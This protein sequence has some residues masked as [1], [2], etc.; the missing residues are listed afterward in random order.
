LANDLPSKALELFARLEAEIVVERAARP[1]VDLE[2]LCLAARA[3]ERDHQLRDEALAIRALVDQ[4]T[5]LANDVR[6]P[7]HGQIRVDADLERPRTK[8]LEVLGIRPAFRVQRNPG[9]D[10]AVPEAESLFREGRGS[11]L[12]AGGGRLGGLVNER[13]EDPRIE[14]G[15]AEV[16]PVA[17]SSSLEGDAMR[18]ENLPKPRH[19]GLEAVR[20]RRRRTTSPHLVDQALIGYD[21]AGTE[22]QGGEN[23]SLLAPAQIESA[24]LDLGFK[25]AEDAKPE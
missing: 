22:Q 10:T 25:R 23:G 13:L 20:C 16:D 3:V 9:E 5:E 11:R 2:R 19:V 17:A 15:W 12:V 4:P 7:P 14:N 8:L 1:L 24:F 6:M 18:R 21:L